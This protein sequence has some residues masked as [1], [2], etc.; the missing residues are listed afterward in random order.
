MTMK[1]LFR[2][3]TSLLRTVL[4]LGAISFVNIQQTTA[5]AL[6]VTEDMPSAF[7]FMNP[8]DV[9]GD[10][11]YYYIQF[12]FDSDI[13]YLSDQGAGNALRSKDYIPFA[14]NLQ[15]TLVSTGTANQ[16]KLKSLNGIFAYLD[17]GAYKGTTDEN[18]A[19]T[20]TFYNHSRKR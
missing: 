6:P 12:Y 2:Y 20:F 10:G 18:T 8:G 7:D 15:W 5:Q 13:S 1:Q 4:L 17:N 19:S 11:N 16:F 9:I 14:K 3:T